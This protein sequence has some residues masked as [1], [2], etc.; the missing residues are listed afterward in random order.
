MSDPWEEA[1]LEPV[2]ARPGVELG[3]VYFIACRET[4]RCKIGF[5]R[6]D[7]LKRLRSLQ[8]GAAGELKLIAMQPGTPETE[9]A[10]HERFAEQRLH[11]EWFE[12]NE[13]LFV[14]MCLT[15]WTMA[16]IYSDKGV[17]PPEWM[18]QGL[19]MMRDM[20]GGPLPDHLEAML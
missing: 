1:S 15:V 13:P 16:G 20:A 4:E 14:Y 10:L 6:G 7:V 3:W 19:R 17:K 5:T 11:G 8:T 9:R 12:M 18:K 2:I